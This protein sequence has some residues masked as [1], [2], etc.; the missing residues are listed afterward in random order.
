M[1]S[2][3]TRGAN[4]RDAS[5]GPA[6]HWPRT[7]YRG[8]THTT[9]QNAP[10]ISARLSRQPRMSREVSLRCANVSGPGSAEVKAP[11]PLQCRRDPLPVSR[12]ACR[13]AARRCQQHRPGPATSTGALLKGM[14]R[15]LAVSAMRSSLAMM[16]MVVLPVPAKA[17]STTRVAERLEQPSRPP[18]GR[19][20][21]T[22]DMHQ[23]QKNEKDTINLPFIVEIHC[24]IRASEQPM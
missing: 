11:R 10:R 5:A 12:A 20:A 18:G 15:P 7:T 14:S 8:T 4:P 24:A 6:N 19:R 23:S 1:G 21:R 22:R 2:G 17:A 3:A 9:S 13:L 16:P